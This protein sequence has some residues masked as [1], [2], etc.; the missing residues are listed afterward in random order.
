MADTNLRVPFR[1]RALERADPTVVL[2]DLGRPSSSDD[3][4]SESYKSLV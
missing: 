1:L 4:G 3:K 2:S